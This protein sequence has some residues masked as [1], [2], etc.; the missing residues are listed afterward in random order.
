MNE[1]WHVNKPLPPAR[2]PPPTARDSELPEKFLCSLNRWD[3]A[4]SSCSVP[5]EGWDGEE[6]VKSFANGVQE[7]LG[8]DQLSVGCMID[9]QVRDG[10]TEGRTP[11]RKG[12]G[13]NA[14]VLRVL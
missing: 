3:P 8:P 12:R 9:A 6:T 11:E 14:C 2:S 7:R 5:E 1:I 4:R 10:G 13:P